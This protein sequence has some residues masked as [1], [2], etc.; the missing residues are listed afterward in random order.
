MWESV[1]SFSEK[2]FWSNATIPKKNLQH[3]AEMQ[4]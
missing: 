2:T 4:R 1:P 3:L